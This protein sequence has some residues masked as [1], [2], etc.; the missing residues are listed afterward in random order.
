MATIPRLRSSALRYARADVVKPMSSPPDHY[1]FGKQTGQALPGKHTRLLYDSLTKRDA[2]VL[3]QLRTGKC[4]LNGYL[5]R[6]QAVES[7]HCACDRGPETVRHFLVQCSQWETMRGRLKMV[8]PQRFGD[9]AFW[10]GGRSSQRQSDGRYVDGE[11]SKMD[12]KSSCGQRNTGFRPS[13]KTVGQRHQY[14]RG[15]MKH[16]IPVQHRPALKKAS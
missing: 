7:D 2:R 14:G 8:F 13:N 1:H 15:D 12:T 3:A 6:I 11:K 10:V 5:A 16:D 4:R 9:L